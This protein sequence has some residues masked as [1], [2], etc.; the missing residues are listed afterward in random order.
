[1]G[2]SFREREF[3]GRHMLAIT[4]T[5]F[6]VIVAVNLSLAYFANATWSGLVVKN[7]Y[8]ASQGFAADLARAKAQDAL[9]WSA[10]LGHGRNRV[11][12]AFKDKAHRPI[13]DLSVSGVLRRPA[14]IARDQA[15]ALNAE[16]NGVYGS[17][18]ELAAGAWEIEITA[19]DTAGASFHKA[20]RFRVKD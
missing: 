19:T 12:I 10:E 8:V 2:A 14:G 20:F 16:G 17:E 1:M 13:G 4:A 9:G 11:S 3:T 6:A 15:L 5:F 7:G 18:A